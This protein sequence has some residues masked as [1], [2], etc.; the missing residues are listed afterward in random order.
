MSVLGVLSILDIGTSVSKRSSMHSN[1]LLPLEPA[2]VRP[3]PV[4][5]LRCTVCKSVHSPGM[6]WV[7]GL[8]QLQR[9]L[10]GELL[11]RF[12]TW[13]RSTASWLASRGYQFSC[14]CLVI[15]R[16]MLDVLH[17]ACSG[18]T[19]TLCKKTYGQYHGRNTNLD[20]VHSQRTQRNTNT[21]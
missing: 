8:Y 15:K 14:W 10:H 4:C 9:L 3:S 7:I 21:E 5:T 12:F 17:G 11:V 2:V 16:L 1:P 20:L 19:N 6:T 18:V 13:N